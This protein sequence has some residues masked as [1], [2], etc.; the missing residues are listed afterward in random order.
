MSS[1]SDTKKTELEPPEPR[2]K[3]WK[4]CQKYCH[5]SICQRDRKT[6]D[7]GR[8]H[9]RKP[10]IYWVTAPDMGSFTHPYT[11][12][13]SGLLFCWASAFVGL[14]WAYFWVAANGGGWG[15]E[16]VSFT[17]DKNKPECY[18]L[19]TTMSMFHT[20]WRIKKWF[21]FLFH[22]SLSLSLCKKWK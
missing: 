3:S 10:N 1:L 20:C 14:H 16:Y 21:P 13:L 8:E 15:T 7:S 11:P 5:N 12:L 6:A 18:G 9:H 4:H 22:P 19:N 17:S 2:L